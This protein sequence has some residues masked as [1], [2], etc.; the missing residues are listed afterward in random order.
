VSNSR[1]PVALTKCYFCGESGDLLIGRQFVHGP[2]KS[3]VEQMDGLVVNMD[4]C[5]KCVDLMKQGVILITI[6]D[7]KSA[8]N[9]DKPEATTRTKASIRH[10]LDGTEETPG[11]PNPYRTGGFFVVTEAAITRLFPASHAAFALKHRWMFI[12][13]EAAEK[14]GLFNTQPTES[15]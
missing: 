14:I 4:P 3:K 10:H 12:E 5:N 8:P 6:D 11:I 1:I 7:A 15:T 13:H 9:W 2:D